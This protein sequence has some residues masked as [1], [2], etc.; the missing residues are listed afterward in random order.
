MPIRFPLVFALS[1]MVIAAPL[2]A[3]AIAYKESPSLAA[4]VSAKT[5]PP[6]ADRL[7]QEPSIADFARDGARLGKQGGSIRMLMAKAK[8]TRQM[9]VYG[10]ARLVGYDHQLLLNADVLKSYKVEEGRIFTLTLR[11]G[12]KWSDGHPFTTEDFRYWWEDIANN[13]ELSPAGPPVKMLADGV[14]PKVDILS[15]TEIR[16]TWPSPNPEFVPALAQASPM[17]IYAPGHY[18][19]QFHGKYA[20]PATLDA[21][22][23]A[24]KRRGWASLHNRKD[25]AYK[26]DNPELPTLQ[27]WVVQTAP[28]AERFVFKRNPFYHRVDA[29]GVQLPYLDEVNIDIVS[30]KLIPAKAGSGEV[31]LQGRYLQFK[32]T[33]FLKQNEEQYNYVT[34]LWRTGKG[35]QLALYPNMNAKDPVWR[36]LFRDVR[37]R[38]AL[39]LATNREEIN[40]VVYFGVALPHNNALLPG[41]PLYSEEAA[42]SYAAF[43][44]KKANALLDDMGLKRGDDGIRLLPDGRKAEIIAES[45]GESTEETDV[46]Q[47]V[48]DTWRKAGIKLYTKPLQRE[49]LRNRVFTGDTLLSIWFG[50]ENGLASPQMSP[51]EFAPTSQQQLQWPMWGQYLETKGEAGEP[52]DMEGPKHLFERYQAWRLAPDADAQEAIWREMI[53]LYADQVYSIGLVSGALQPVVATKNLQNVPVEGYYNWDPGA[54]FGCYRPDGFWL[55]SK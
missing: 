55:S 45:A 48:H 31:D 40:E 18:L 1:A 10:Y 41:S 3:M 50:L 11:K 8:E 19:K 2:N 39:S 38:R 25:N 49:V 43:D 16:F 33:P 12:H 6:V 9:V 17:Y 51:E 29:N 4:A 27:P 30:G 46:L 44:L 54:H 53:K 47:L 22:V 21:M 15:E 5:L 28:P 34:H 42:L 20:E 35:A 36:S 23:K 37:F 7:P 24:A 32:D 14:P 13:K 26:N 52:I